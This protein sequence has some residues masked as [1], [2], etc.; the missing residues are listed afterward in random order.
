MG[1]GGLVWGVMLRLYLRSGDRRGQLLAAAMAVIDSR[2][3]AGLT[4]A[5]VAAEASVTRQL[6]YRHFDDVNALLL[7]LL[8]D[9]FDADRADPGQA[10]AGKRPAGLARSPALRAISRPA[11]D[12][13]LLP[14]ARRA[15][16]ER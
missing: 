11:P 7:A 15:Y 9:R 16:A 14:S 10:R 13:R 8:A 12:P 6:V 1:G 4:I 3:L 2:G 5:N